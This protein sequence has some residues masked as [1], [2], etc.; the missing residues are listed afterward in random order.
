MCDT[1]TI[2][3]PRQMPNRE[4]QEHSTL[5]TI[6]LQI[7]QPSLAR[8][9]AKRFLLLLG[10]M[11]AV[12]LIAVLVLFRTAIYHRFVT[13]PRQVAALKAI[14][15]K[16]VPIP[17]ATGWTEYR[18]VSHSHSLLSHDS[19]VPWEHILKTMQETGRQFICMSDHCQE[20]GE[21]YNLQWRGVHGGVLFI[22]GFEMSNNIM[23]WGLPPDTVL[24]CGDPQL[25]TTQQVH[26][27]GGVVFIVHP[28]E[29]KDWDDPNINGMEIYNLHADFMDEY[30]VK[31]TMA[32]TLLR[33][34]PDILMNIGA[35]PDQTL[36]LIF[37]RN[38]KMLKKWDELNVTR[39]IVGIC[40]NDC[41]QNIGVYG[42]WQPDASIKLRSPSKED[43]KTPA[44]LQPLLRLFSAPF[45]PGKEAFR[46]QIDPYERSTRYVADHVLARELT[47]PAVI[48]A[49]REGR[50]FVAF[51]MLAD[52]TGFVWMAKGGGR[53]A[54]MGE[55]IALGDDTTL[56]AAAPFSCR[57]T[58][59]RH[60]IQVLQQ[61]GASLEWKPTETGKYRVEAELNILGEWTP[62]V[63]A[64]PIEVVAAGAV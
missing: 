33:L 37:D 55:K 60:G 26:D 47:E 63:Y 16:P 8:R 42:V 58:V 14:Q 56:L 36:R 7:N 31:G 18:G 25:V 59:L 4:R 29:K 6:A 12:F 43:I 53:Q 54:V 51:D 23:P 50:V 62:W 40:G 61:E 44:C 32:Q 5:A 10:V 48:D 27:K 57:F 1:R 24:H 3:A 30:L 39:K 64:N 35:Y 46:F 34:A 20:G 13:F 2:I 28:E 15:A 21:A 49:L 17:Y 19:E 11:F 9:I 38:V 52:S 41:H 45:A 22:P